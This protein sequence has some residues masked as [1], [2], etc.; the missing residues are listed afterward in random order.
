MVSCQVASFGAD[1]L[2]RQ[3]WSEALLALGADQRGTGHSV[4]EPATDRAGATYAG[5]TA[6][7]GS[8]S[9]LNTR[10]SQEP[11]GSGR[12]KFTSV[13][14]TTSAEHLCRRRFA[15]RLAT[16]WVKRKWPLSLISPI[17]RRSWPS[18]HANHCRRA[19]SS[20]TSCPAIQPTCIL[21]VALYEWQ[22]PVWIRASTILIVC[23]D[24]R[25]TH[26]GR[27]S[28]VV[29]T[30][31]AALLLVGAGDRSAADG[32]VKHVSACAARPIPGRCCAPVAL[33]AGRRYGISL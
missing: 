9:C 17:R 27:R 15:R 14:D 26:N 3:Q 21:T 29:Q 19:A 33:P 16:G 5:G 28:T 24:A 10:E 30:A 22:G 8:P 1:A 20:G 6:L 18:P 25:D 23:I 2:H 11:R 7:A 12:R 32:P 13:D 4:G 31:P